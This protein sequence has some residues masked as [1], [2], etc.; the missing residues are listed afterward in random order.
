MNLGSAATT[1]YPR[2]RNTLWAVGSAAVSSFTR[3]RSSLAS[4]SVRS[5]LG[6]A[7]PF[8]SERSR[9]TACTGAVDAFAADSC[10]E[11]SGS[12]RAFGPL[13]PGVVLFVRGAISLSSLQRTPR[14][15]REQLARGTSPPSSGGRRP[16]ALDELEGPH[17]G[18]HAAISA[19][20][21][22]ARGP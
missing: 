12:T 19:L 1:K 4:A 7:A 5:G 18:G 22:H 13:P 20:P 8:A 2:L 10:R 3:S 21:G 11:S 6:A 16:S 14:L 9:K 15:A 17:R